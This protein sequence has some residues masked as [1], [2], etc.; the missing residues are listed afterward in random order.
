MYSKLISWSRYAFLAGI[1][2]ALV[3]VIPTAW[4]PFQLAKVAVF[5]LLALVAV[6]LFVFGRGTRE[7]VRARGFFG[8]LLVALLPLAYLISAYFSIDRSVAFTGFGVESD[9]VLFTALLFLTF[10]IAFVLFRTLRTV[11][12]LLSVV[13]WSLIVAVI[14]QL[15]SVVFGSAA[16]PL[17]T[18]ADRSVNLIGKWNDLGIIGGLLAMLLLVRVELQ[19]ASN[20]WRIVV[21]I[22]LAALALLLGIINF[23]LVWALVLGFAVVISILHLLMRRGGESAAF[24]HWAKRLPWFAIGSA[25]VSILFLF[26]GSM[27]NTH[28][29]S[30]FPVSSLEVRP[31]YSSTLTI[32]DAARAGSLERTLIGTGPNTFGQ[33]WLLHKP[34]EVN[35]SEF[36]NLDFNV[37]FSTLVTALGTVGLLGALMWLIPILLILAALVRVVR[38][39]VLSRED[40]IVASTLSVTS[41]FLLFTIF[42]YEPSQNIIILAFALAGATFGFLWRQ[43]QSAAP[44]EESTTRLSMYGTLAAIIIVVA[45]AAYVGVVTG[46]RLIAE[47]YTGYGTEQL[48]N[49]DAN[50]AVQSGM[51]A[52][53]IDPNGDA[54]RLL[55]NAYGTQLQTMAASTSTSPDLQKQFTATVQSAITASQQAQKLNPADYR[56]TLAL[57][58]VYDFLSTLKVQAAAQTALNTYQQAAAE[59]PTNPTI[60]LDIA[61]LAANQGNQQIT[62]TFLSQALTLKP[63]YTDAILLVVQLDVAN[64]DIPNAIKAA[65]AAAQTAPGDAPIWFELGLLYYSS[66]DA[67]HAE[68]ALQQAVTIQPDYANAKYFLGLSDYI[69][70]DNADAIKQFQDLAASNPGNTEVTLILSNLQAGKDPFAGAQPPVTSTPQNRT[71]APVTQ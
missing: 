25:L 59:D 68:Q 2:L 60:P 1:V 15:I 28:L 11:R 69:L 70:K 9:T 65:T 56:P 10:A 27:L 8:V 58:Q 5:A 42:L 62:T 61:R 45:L 40:N 35:Q 34:A 30:L 71:T 49:G 43:G 13:F 57:A 31:S 19:T 7:V 46:R 17:A 12:I 23:S 14:F 67:T 55:V 29:T 63:N 54:L 38:L 44:Q 51:F 21:G 3:L 47:A 18:F 24:S 26:F 20:A 16:I 22:A 41:L 39:G 64:K 33:E 53:N 52:Q 48:S 36:W 4:F 6:V 32:I 66:G 37:G 50:G